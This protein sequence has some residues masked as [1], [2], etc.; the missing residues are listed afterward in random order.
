M[1]VIKLYYSL[2]RKRLMSLLIAPLLFCLTSGTSQTILDISP[3]KI[4][5]QRNN[6]TRTLQIKYINQSDKPLL[7]WV[8]DWVINYYAPNVY[9]YSSYK[10]PFAN[11]IYIQKS[12]E[13]NQESFDYSYS[14]NEYN[15]T[16]F[17]NYQLLDVNESL[18]VKLE[19]AEKIFQEVKNKPHE[20]LIVY[21]VIDVINLKSQLTKA[22]SSQQNQDQQSK[23]AFDP[24]IS[25]RTKSIQ[26]FYFTEIEWAL[27]LIINKKHKPDNQNNNDSPLKLKPLV[28]LKILKQYASQNNNNASCEVIHAFSKQYS[29]KVR[30]Q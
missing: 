28:E 16:N 1:F 7:L 20:A 15:H 17:A 14:T 24:L 19:A 27:P 21:S 13:K 11:I 8:G 29:V 3:L 30:I 2:T 18:T 23:E 6:L 12:G 4:Y 10:S 25:F 9:R 22:S 26:N 5:A